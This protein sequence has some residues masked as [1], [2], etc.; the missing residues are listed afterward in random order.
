MSSGSG[1]SGGSRPPAGEHQDPEFRWLYGGGQ[2][3]EQPAADDATRMM[4]AAT[5]PAATPPAATPPATQ[6]PSQRPSIDPAPPSAPRRRFRLPRLR[7]LRFRYL[8]LLVLAWIVFLVAVPILAWNDVDKVPFEPKADRPGN[9]PGTTYLLVGTDSRDDLSKQQRRDLST[10]YVAGSRTDTIMLLHTG[11]GPNLLLSLPRDS[12]VDIPGYGTNKI[13]AAYAFGGPRLL[14]RTIEGET[15]IHIDHYVEIGMGGVAGIVDAVGGIRVCPKTAMTDPE[16]GLKI[17]RGCQEVDGTTALGYARSRK[18]SSIGDI[19]RVR[20]QREVVAA[21]GKKVLG[22]MTVINPVT[23]WQINN[24]VPGF[25]TFGEGMGPTRSLMWAAAMAR[26]SGKSGLTCVVPLQ[27]LAVN[28]DPELAPQ[29]F[30]KIIDDDTESIGKKLCSPT[31]G[32][33]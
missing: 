12:I 30:A 15:G 31:G 24:A 8:F 5:P 20:R 14:T 26:V 28:W 29:M 3:P 23:W 4:P 17:T 2:T 22:P 27:D 21:I 16:A 13:N 9:Q 7:L 32:I 6:P 11:A 1:G 10:G 18:T 19:D 25:F 33:E